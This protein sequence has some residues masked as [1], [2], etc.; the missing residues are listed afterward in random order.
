MHNHKGYKNKIP[1]KEI[2]RNGK[3]HTKTLVKFDQEFFKCLN[4]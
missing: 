4:K 1:T 2:K 3:T